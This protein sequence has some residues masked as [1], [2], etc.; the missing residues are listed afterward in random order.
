MYRRFRRWAIRG[1][2][3][4]LFRLLTVELLDLGTIMVDGT[5]VKVH[6]HGAGSPKADALPVEKPKAKVAEG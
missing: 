4:K 3:A 1:T 2:L 5:F 6:Q